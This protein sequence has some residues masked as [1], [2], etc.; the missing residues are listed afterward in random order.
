MSALATST[1]R[2]PRSDFGSVLRNSMLQVERVAQSSLA[3]AGPYL[4]GSAIVSAALAGTRGVVGSS[5]SPVPI[6]GATSSLT[7]GGIRSPEGGITDVLAATQ[8]MAEF[9][10]AFSLRYLQ[11]QQ[12][13]QRDTREF[14]M[15]S[16][17]LK[18]KHEAAANALANVR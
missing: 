12:A 6:F 4:P 8:S 7:A 15:V 14:N 9:Q 1:R 10:A 16:N 11:L 2:T 3:V 5:L 18:T 17:I 13:V